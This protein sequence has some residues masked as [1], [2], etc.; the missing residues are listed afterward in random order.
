MKKKNKIID[1]SFKTDDARS[2]YLKEVLEF[3]DKKEKKVELLEQEIDA[4]NG[5]TYDEYLII[6]DTNKMVKSLNRWI[7]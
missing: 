1:Y 2:N 4:I 5:L 7:K 6:E 3:E